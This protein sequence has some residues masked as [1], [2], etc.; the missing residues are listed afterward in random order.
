M[1]S[2]V[3]KHSEMYFMNYD[4]FKHTGMFLMKSNVF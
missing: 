4:H 2:N 3:F 1:N